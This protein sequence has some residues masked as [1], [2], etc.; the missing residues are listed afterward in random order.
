MNKKIK[1]Y[2]M[3]HVTDLKDMLRNSLEKYGERPL[4][5][6]KDK[7]D[8]PY[9]PITYN[10]YGADV[11]ALGTA[12]I[13]RGFKG[14]RVAV[15]GENSYGWTTGYM[16]VVAGVGVVVPIDKELPGEEIIRMVARADVSAIIFS[17]RYFDKIKEASAN[18]PTVSLYICMGSRQDEELGNVT[19]A[20]LI[21]EGRELIAKGDTSYDDAVI[22][23]YEM[24]VLL[25]TSGTTA[26]AKAVMLSQHN[27]V[28]N[29]IA[30]GSM[31]EVRGGTCLSILPMHHTYECT[32]GFLYAVY[33]GC[34]LAFCDGLKYIQKN[35]CE[36]HV[37][38]I[39][40]VP[41]LLETMYKRIWDNIDKQGLR[42]KVETAI[43]ISNGL[44]KVGINLTDKLFGQ[45]KNAFGG[46]LQKFVVGAAPL[47]P[48]ICKGFRDLGIEVRQGYG[49]T[50]CAPIIA[51]GPDSF[52]KDEAVGY[53]MPGVEIRIDHPDE[54]G[55]GEIIA[56]GENIM[57]GYYEDKE[58]T[59][60]A[61]IDGWFH[62]GDIGCM[63]EDGFVY[64]TGRCKNMIL[65]KNGKNVFPEE[66]EPMVLELD[67]VKEC[68]VYEEK[69]GGDAK[70][71]CMVYPDIDV[72]KEKYSIE[73][74]PSKE[75]MEAIIFDEIKKTINTK[76]VS[77]KAIRAVH[78]RDKEFVK[79]TTQKIKRHLI[80][81]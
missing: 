74:D 67:T 65:T 48:E 78:V 22:D 32:C 60:A 34:T 76:L 51:L 72:I 30:M 2:K 81:E 80:N 23:P 16:A 8:Q 14:K 31:V 19:T 58:A 59:D 77:Y 6:V 73:G 5:L 47:K 10:E 42:S 15:L 25:F 57:M 66:I 71:A 53:P 68:V 63:D 20:A 54:D 69:S 52:Y 70:I 12:L 44:R 3:D 27:I 46:K 61:I 35:M 18:M 75:K 41:L 79:T 45:I 28:T 49:L 39:L 17:E 11:K 13:A 56:R 9:R 24:T 50:E 7:I 29:L 26:T 43:R 4:F 40:T 55:N 64:I 38:Y 36:A 1:L 37:T 21:A 33:G 62:T